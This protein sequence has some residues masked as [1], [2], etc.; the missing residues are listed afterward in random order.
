MPTGPEHPR[1]ELPTPF[2][3][4][5]R[6]AVESFALSRGQKSPT[7]DDLLF[8]TATHP[9]TMK[10]LEELGV[11]TGGLAQDVRFSMF[12]WKPQ[13]DEDG[14]T[15]ISP[16]EEA[17]KSLEQDFEVYKQ[18]AH[19]I[20]HPI[21]QK[22]VLD[23]MKI[24]VD[25]L[26]RQ[27]GEAQSLDRKAVNKIK[28]TLTISL[29]E[30]LTDQIINHLQDGE[31]GVGGSGKE[32]LDG[33]VQFMQQRL[34]KI[35]SGGDAL[36]MLDA[37]SSGGKLQSLT[38][39]QLTEIVMSRADRFSRYLLYRNGFLA[40]EGYT[41][42]V[43]MPHYS[44]SRHALEAL[45]FVSDK[46]TE[47]V[48]VVHLLP[49]VLDNHVV[50]SIIMDLEKEEASRSKRT[51]KTRSLVS[52]SRAVEK[53][54][55]GDD[56][57][58]RFRRWPVIRES[59]K[60]FLMGVET[61]VAQ[62]PAQ[63]A[64]ARLF[65]ELLAQPDVR[66][67]LAHAGFSSRHIMK[68]AKALKEHEKKY[69]DEEKEK[70]KDSGEFKVGDY[71]FNL[72]LTEYT[73][74]L[75]E[76][77]KKE[78]LDPII[79][80]QKELTQMLKIFLRKNR[81]NPLLLGEPGVGK[82]ALFSGLAQ[83]IA[84]GDVPK[85]LIGARVL[86]VDLSAMNSGAMYRG[87]FEERF[88]GL[89][90]GVAERNDRGD[91][92]PYILCID[93]IHASLQAGVANGTPG[94]AEL[95]KPYLTSGQLKV[96]G[97]TTEA[98]YAKYILIDG[99]LDRR[100]QPIIVDEP[101][102]SETEKIL[103]GLKESFYNHHQ[104]Q[105]ADELVPLTVA[106]TSRYL[107]HLHQPDN[108]ISALDTAMAWSRMDGARELSR[109]TLVQTIATAAR[110]DAQ[111][112][113]EDES[114]RY[115]SLPE[116]LPQEVLGQSEAMQKIASAIIIAKAGLQDPH[117]PLVKYLLSGPTGVGKTETG[118]A[119]SRLMFG[120]EDAMVRIDM[121][122]YREP[123]EATRL[124]G[125][126]PGYVGYGEEG[127]L[128]A[129]VRKNPHCVL[130]FDEVEEAH[131][132]VL[133]R[134]LPIFEE[135]EIADSRGKKINFRN[136]IIL[137][138]TNLGADTGNYKRAIEGWLPAKFINRLDGMLIYRSL[139][140]EI[141]RELVI[142]EISEVSARVQKR[143]GVSLETSESVQQALA[144]FGYSPQYGARELKRTV[145]DMLSSPLS[146][147]LFSQ[148]GGLTQGGIVRIEKIHPELIASISS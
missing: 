48:D 68:W 105:V 15:E 79:G 89:I 136:A 54:L 65:G 87:Q 50:S 118:R 102:V 110:I 60:K 42:P 66:E 109:E 14:E 45:R 111:F 148:N 86:V 94:A 1:S 43:R 82:S 7:F 131:P 126:P 134:L 112:L 28:E 116:T 124:V 11:S 70:Q 84:S 19:D 108:A 117:R 125:A 37:L 17:L 21:G 67:V 132:V 25:D 49:G 103:Y 123:F 88:F 81:S 32:A 3:V 107:P 145:R 113:R 24:V 35:V 93:E 20:S 55:A 64:S 8:V 130:V 36:T 52:L 47:T 18:W 92:P 39:F 71:K 4:E 26:G 91:A 29:F 59:L 122:D 40:P 56:Q 46:R 6:D 57:A 120:S 72:I 73:T 146:P 135:G 128:I 144:M 62:G 69:Y 106:L 143:W 101:P 58:E 140:E 100:F 2:Y 41:A 80:R 31:A 95:F 33:L 27:I 12:F 129:A 90:Q 115:L 9:K 74:D 10:V 114:I 13:S 133:N 5:F 75:T 44:V 147:W 16:F 138:T 30:G 98:D 63:Y 99:A 85:E 104:I 76:L 51:K 53:E 96:V 34:R 127:M 137:L 139:T 23:F 121:T 77:A 78:K 142:R 97:A 38:P 22:A 61:V 141:V 83:R 119:L